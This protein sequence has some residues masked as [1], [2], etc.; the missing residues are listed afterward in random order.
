[1]IQFSRSLCNSFLTGGEDCAIAVFLL[2]KLDGDKCGLLLGEPLSI[3]KGFFVGESD[4]VTEGFLVMVQMILVYYLAAQMA[5]RKV[6]DLVSLLVSCY[7]VL[8]WAV[9]IRVASE[10]LRQL[11]V[12]K[13]LLREY[14]IAM[15]TPVLLVLMKLVEKVSK[16]AAT[17]LVL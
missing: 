12:W 10:L 9:C 1:L 14:L 7:V 16:Q 17:V 11:V 3:T 8:L 15:S 13:V 4:V 2:Y 5:L 6:S